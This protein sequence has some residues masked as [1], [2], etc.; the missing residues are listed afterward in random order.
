MVQEEMLFKDIF[1]LKLW[2]PL[3]VEQNDLCNFGEV[4]REKQFCEIILNLDLWIRRR[5][6]LKIFLT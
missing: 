3:S 1:Y 6:C 2:W 4:H 5:W